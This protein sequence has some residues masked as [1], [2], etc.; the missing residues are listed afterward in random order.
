M[1]LQQ[2]N[3]TTGRAV[4]YPIDSVEPGDTLLAEILTASSAAQSAATA[5]GASETAAKASED[6]ALLSEVNAKNSEMAAK[7]SEN[8][9]SISAGE[10]LASEQAAKVSEGNALASENNAKTAELAAKA[11][12]QAAEVSEANAKT[13]ETN[14]KASED[15]ALL[16]EDN[17]LLSEVNAKNS[18]M[19]AKSY[20]DSINPEL[21]QQKGEKNVANGYAGLDA[22]GKIPGELLNI[23][24]PVWGSISGTLANQ[25][26]LQT[27][28]DGKSPA[29]HSHNDLYY[30]ETEVDTK[31]AGKANTSHSHSYAPIPSSSSLPV[32][33]WCFCYNNATSDIANGGTIAGSNLK[34]FRLSLSNSSINTGSFLAGSLSGTWKN[35]TGATVKKHHEASGTETRDCGLFVRTA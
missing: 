34:I 15:N 10:G 3:E 33:M 35:I 11:S 7:A 16:S 4:Q 25:T 14:A 21:L 28:L 29:S 17:A 1:I 20:A 12:E 6:N 23:T 27:A 19:A 9:S 30:T 31:L 22:T 32:G 13:S 18:E 5:A 2:V 24:D 26:D 8:A